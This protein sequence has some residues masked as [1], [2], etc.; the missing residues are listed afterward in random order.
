MNSTFG[1][2]T[3]SSTHFKKGEVKIKNFTFDEFTLTNQKASIPA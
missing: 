1:I 2:G 3:S